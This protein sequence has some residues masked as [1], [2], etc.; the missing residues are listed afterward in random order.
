[1]QTPFT[2]GSAQVT[3]RIATLLPGLKRSTP[4]IVGWP[5]RVFTV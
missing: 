4:P 1:V 2:N 5:L 3:S